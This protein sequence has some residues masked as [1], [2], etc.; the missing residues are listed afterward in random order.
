MPISNEEWRHLEET[1]NRLRK[2]T[3]DTTNWAGGGHIGGA[4]S[5][6][7]ALT[8]LYHH[9][10]NFSAQKM[11]DPERDRFVLSKG[12]IGVGM[13]AVLADLGCFPKEWL[14]RFSRIGS[15][16]GMHLDANKVPGLEVS[17]GSLGHGLS[18]AVGLALGARYQKQSWR[19]YCMLG[20]AETD[21]GSIWEAAMSAAHYKLD[22]LCAMVDVNHAMIDGFT[23]DVMNLEP[24]PDKWR[25]FGWH[26]IE[27]KG[28]NIPALVDA[29][30]EAASVKG[31]PTMLLLDTVKG[32][33]IDFMEG[34]YTWHYGS[35]DEEKYAK[36]EQSLERHLA[37]RL[38][39]VKGE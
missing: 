13:A 32:E 38:A 31:Q 11:D 22:N 29:F 26:V 35:V 5:A 36:A 18:M 28:N 30:D 8:V 6:M 23:K 34:D 17:A 33:G 15:P 2:L 10:L 25:A 37:K 19:T 39:N 3:L 24:Y 4:M 7:D 20:D 9:T 16:L 12:H 21:E 27:L 14:E 1:A